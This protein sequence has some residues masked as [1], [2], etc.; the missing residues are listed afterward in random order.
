MEISMTAHRVAS[1]VFDY[2]ATRFDDAVKYSVCYGGTHPLS[3]GENGVTIG[4]VARHYGSRFWWATSDTGDADTL[5]WFGP[6]TSRKE[7][8]VFLVGAR[9]ERDMPARSTIQ[10]VVRELRSA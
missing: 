6:F 8:S 4:D 10:G 3:P 7:A 2:C 9:I 1:H 5:R